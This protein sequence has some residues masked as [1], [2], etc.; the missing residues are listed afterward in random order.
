MKLINALHKDPKWN[1]QIDWS[2]VALVG[3]SL[4]GYT[5]LALA[6]AW[7][8]WKQPEI[9]AVLALSP[10]CQPFV[11]HGKLNNIKI[12]VMYQGGTHDFGITPIIKNLRGAFNKT[13]SPA[14]FVEFDKLGHLGWTNFN[15]NQEQKELINY[16]CLAFLDKFVKGDRNAKPDAKLLGVF[17]LRVK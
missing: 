1:L 4:G 6:G 15:H 17:D 13:S 12:P 8:S 11:M 10:Y 2:R 5:V 7:L 3:H 9:K 16:Y 14:Y